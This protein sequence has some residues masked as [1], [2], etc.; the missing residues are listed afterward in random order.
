MIQDWLVFDSENDL[1][2]SRTELR[3]GS[4]VIFIVKLSCSLITEV[5]PSVPDVPEIDVEIL[6]QMLQTS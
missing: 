1:V 5:V 6:P 3:P 4:F 2:S